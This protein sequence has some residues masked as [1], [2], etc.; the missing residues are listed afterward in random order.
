MSTFE[1]TRTTIRKVP[2]WTWVAVSGL[3]LLSGA[4]LLVMG[5][6]SGP[7][8]T[9]M[10]QLDG[11]PLPTGWIRFVPVEGTPGSDG[12]SPIREGI[13]SIPPGLSVGKY[14]VEIQGTQKIAGKMTRHPITGELIP[15]E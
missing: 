10:V 1:K 15:D 9:G 3:L 14:K 8:V 12:G 4:L 11:R 7:T 6:K 5:L 2:R 13:Y